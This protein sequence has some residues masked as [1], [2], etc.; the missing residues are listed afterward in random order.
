MADFTGHSY[1]FENAV[2]IVTGYLRLEEMFQIPHSAGFLRL[3]V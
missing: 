1:S 2:S 3:C